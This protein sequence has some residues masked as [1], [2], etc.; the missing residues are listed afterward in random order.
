[1]S[2]IRHRA[3]FVE[4]VLRERDRFEQ[5]LNRVGYARRMTLKGVA[6][7]WSIKDML[8]HIWAYEQFLADR[9][10]EIQNGQLHTPG[11]TQSA[12][13]AFLDEFGYPDFGSPLLDADAPGE[14][15]VER[16]SHVSLDDLV[17]QEIEA[18]CAIVSALETMPEELILRHNLYNRIAQHT[19]ERYREHAREIRRWL[20]VN[21]AQ[22]K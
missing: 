19:Y 14:W 22:L 13:D 15:V 16:Y 8:A 21:G 17:A 18:F 7:K 20:R 10:A 9:M 4:R 6:G 11:K 2:N 3:I 5:L 12:L 1:M